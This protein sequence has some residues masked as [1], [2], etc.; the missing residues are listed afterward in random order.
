LQGKF[1]SYAYCLA[2]IHTEDEGL[3]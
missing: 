2:V 3:G 1:N